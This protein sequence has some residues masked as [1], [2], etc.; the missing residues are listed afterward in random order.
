MAGDRP[1]C[2]GG[3]AGVAGELLRIRLAG[4]SPWW[5][6]LQGAAGLEEVVSAY[7]QRSRW[8]QGKA[9]T[10]IGLS[11]VELVHLRGDDTDFPIMFVSVRYREGTPEIYQIP[12]AF[13]T[14][15][16]AARLAAD[17]P[18]AVLAWLTVGARQGVLCDALHDP[19]FRELFLTFMGDRRRLTGERGGVVTVSDTGPVRGEPGIE[20]LPS[21]VLGGEQTNST[22]IYGDR[23]VL[24]LYR[25]VE[26][27]IT[28]EAEVSRFLTERVR[29]RHVPPLQGVVTLR[30]EGGESLVLAVMHGHVGNQGDAW[31][32]SLKLLDRFFGRML[33]RPND[34]PVMPDSSP[35]IP[36][37]SRCAPP[38][39]AVELP[40]SFPPDM[41]GLLGRRTAELHLALAAGGDD[42]V[43]CREEDSLADRQLLCR[44]LGEQ[45]RRTLRL[46]A[47]ARLNLAGEELARADRV[48]AAGEEIM[49][50]QERVAALRLDA[51]RIRIHGDLHLGQVLCTGSDFVFIDFEGEPARSLAERRSKHSPLRDVA[52]MLRSFHYATQTA[53][54]RHSA[55]DPAG[56]AAVETLAQCWYRDVSG[57]FWEEYRE[58]IAGS[59]LLPAERGDADTLHRAFLL[60][61]ALYEVVYEL[62]NRPGWV[63]IPLRGI[64]M[65]LQG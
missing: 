45:A 19:T 5:E 22:V 7:L 64:E 36:E 41:P 23:H 21:E 51:A 35:G 53:L 26:P 9:G 63:G 8:F 2:E 18:R 28:P 55:G 57:R 52:G 56:R 37:W 40:G 1:R 16:G 3:A 32:L 39:M 12:T 62:N 44:S 6:E 42:P 58:R 14:G 30:Q 25:R 20:V 61:K 59:A 13:L 34:V 46:L 4:E 10:V 38:A 49:A 33:S 29:F 17:S 60:D 27:G 54:A 48:L 15:P 50:L 43:W 47:Q 24:K 31:S 65:I 11:L